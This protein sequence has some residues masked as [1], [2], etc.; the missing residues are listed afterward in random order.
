MLPSD[1]SQPLITNM[2]LSKLRM[3][4]GNDRVEILQR[5]YN[6]TLLAALGAGTV[7]LFSIARIRPGQPP[8]ALLVH[9]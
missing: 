4:V 2:L 6:W 7:M 8:I 1:G 5:Q 3:S 9:Y